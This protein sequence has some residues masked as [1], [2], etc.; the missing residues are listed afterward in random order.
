M[1]KRLYVG[2]VSYQVT[3]DDLKELFS[4]AGQVVSVR[5]ITDAATGR[6]RG[7][8]FVEFGTDAEAEKAITMYDET[9]FMNRKLVVRVAKEREKPA[10]GRRKTSYFGQR[11]QGER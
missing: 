7:F 1:A 8:G 5:L 6:L 11:G 10:P 2:N 3:E 4:K 9:D